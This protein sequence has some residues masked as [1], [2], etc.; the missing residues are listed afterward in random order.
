ME[1]G[2]PSKTQKEEGSIQHVEK[3]NM[4]LSRNIEMFSEDAGM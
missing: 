4:P 2:A 1:Q 3:R